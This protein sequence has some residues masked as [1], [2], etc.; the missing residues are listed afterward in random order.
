MLKTLALKKSYRLE[1]GPA[2]RILN[3]FCSKDN[4]DL[5]K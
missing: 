3:G 5:E 2:K 1:S 4:Y